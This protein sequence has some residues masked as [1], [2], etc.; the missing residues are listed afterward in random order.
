MLVQ[1]AVDH[2]R[3]FKE[4][5]E[6]FFDEFITLFF[7][8]LRREIDLTGLRFLQQE[9]FTDVTTGDKHRVD[10]L[11]EVRLKGEEGLILVHIENQAQFQPDFAER[12]FVYFA[13]LYQKFRRKILPIAVFSYDMLHDETDNFRIEF[14]FLKVLHFRFYTLELKKRPWREYIQSDNPV[15]AALLSKMGYQPEEKVQVKLEFMR[16]LTRMRLDPARMTLLAGFFETYLRL[17]ADEEQALENELRKL[18]VKEVQKMMEITTS[19]HEKGRAEGIMEIAR[20][21][22]LEGLATPLVA[23]ITGLPEV[24]IA[25]LQQELE[26]SSH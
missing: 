1:D 3:L 9:I 10:L 22:L 25:K 19:W 6:T 11:A 13:R 4:L 8:E 15:A 23:K 12:M 18:D 16:M 24:E 14:P 5:L 26:A 2:D 20:K 7:P 17:N 21:M